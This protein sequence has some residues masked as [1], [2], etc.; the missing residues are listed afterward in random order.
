MR[1][2]IFI[3]IQS[4]P[5]LKEIEQSDCKREPHLEIRPD[6]LTQMFKFANLRQKRE[7]SFDQHPIIP[8]ASSAKLQVFRLIRFAP[9]ASICQNNR[10]AA[11]FFNQRQKFLI[12]DI[13][14]FDRP[15]GN[16]SEFVGQKAEFPTDNPLP[17][18]KAFASDSFSFGLMIFTNR[19]TQLDA[20]RINHSED[21]RLGKKLFGQSPMRLQAAKK[22]G[23]FRQIGKKVEPILS[24]PAIELVLRR[25]FQSHQQAQSDK[26]AQGKLGLIMFG[27]F[28]QHIVYTTKKSYDKLFLSHAICFLCVV[29]GHL[30]FRNFHVTFSTSTNG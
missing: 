25:A 9:K 6:S 10:P 2:S 29:F 24:E 14:C 23:S 13:R 19:M 16:E 11:K 21:G 15:I 4:I 7:N 3:K 27:R 20:V 5:L 12:R 22:S 1:N 8:L 30:H 17:G 26:F 18:S 28:R